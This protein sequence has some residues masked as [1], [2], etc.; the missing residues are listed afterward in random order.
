M[1]FGYRMAG[2]E[3]GKGQTKH[4]HLIRPTDLE[5]VQPG[6]KETV[7][8]GEKATAKQWLGDPMRAMAKGDD[9]NRRVVY[10]AAMHAAEG[11]G[12]MGPYAREWARAVNEQTFTM[13]ART[14]ADAWARSVM[15]DSQGDIGP[16]SMNPMYRGPV[17]GSLRPFMKFP[18]LLTRN[19]IDMVFQPDATGRNRF[20][21]ATIAAVYLGKQIGL[22][23]EDTLLMSGKPFG[24]DPG[25]P[26]Q[27]L[28]KILSGD[29][30]PGVK[31]IKHG[32]AHATG[33]AKDVIFPTSMEDIPN[34]DLGYLLGGRYPMK[35]LGVVNRTLESDVK[36][37]LRGEKGTAHMTRTASG[38]AVP[39]S[40]LEDLLSLTGYKST[41]V[42]DRAEK[43]SQATSEKYQGDADRK[44]QSQE[45][46]R[47]MRVASDA[48]HDD[49]VA[50]LT[51]ELVTLTKSPQ[52]AVNARK[53]LNRTG[54]DRLIAQSSPRVRAM[55][56]E[57]YG[58]QMKAVELSK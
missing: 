14:E 49:E 46:V 13:A 2:T 25:N 56:Q 57:K 44:G 9:F 19:L 33:Q 35:L 53:G 50:R 4:V 5:E 10:L 31:A 51:Q 23:L 32:Y 27:A 21:A 20:I 45:L 24:V 29:I 16:L 43:L 11:K 6:V 12:L 22:N 18:T 38:A 8:V 55:I 36:P 40:L 15:R 30:F 17:G 34:S 28:T 52:S 54:W 41:R 3:W 26:K 7:P 58:A 39:V 47:Q 37:A 1:A 48:G 42:S